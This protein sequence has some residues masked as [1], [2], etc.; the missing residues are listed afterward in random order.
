MVFSQFLCK[1]RL[2]NNKRGACLTEGNS[3]LRFSSVTI[4]YETNSER[5][6][7]MGRFMAKGTSKRE[8]QRQVKRA[9]EIKSL[10]LNLAVKLSVELILKD[11]QNE[12]FT[13]GT[14]TAEAITRIQAEAKKKGYKEQCFEC[15]TEIDT[16]GI[17]K[18]CFPD[19]Y[20][21]LAKSQENLTKETEKKDV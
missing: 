3:Q 17:C 11:P 18:K 9:N 12:V 1:V 21:S 13:N 16:I 5:V 4:N 2:T 15:G 8:L 10:C 20:A 14:L 19:E 6:L 7:Q